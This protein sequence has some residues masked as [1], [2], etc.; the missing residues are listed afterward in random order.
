MRVRYRALA[1]LTLMV[2]A[3]ALP[4]SGGVAAGRTDYAH[5]P[6]R[7]SWGPVEIR[8][9]AT[10][11]TKTGSDRAVEGPV[12]TQVVCL[13]VRDNARGRYEFGCG[14][15]TITVEPLL[16]RATINGEIA[17]EVRR[18]NQSSRLARSR[19]RLAA[20]MPG[21]GD[22]TPLRWW[23]HYACMHRLPGDQAGLVSYVAMF[24]QAAGSVSFRSAHLGSY[25]S[26]PV[27]QGVIYAWD[28]PN[29]QASPVPASLEETCL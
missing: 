9:G 2:S 23:G 5:V 14:T 25:F 28:S 20:E 3:L 15:M 27:R 24:R 12:T 17:T 18:I 19:I 7:A 22:L 16:M 29:A 11:I 21:T 10:K 6:G 8:F 13:H 26:K 1:G 4:A